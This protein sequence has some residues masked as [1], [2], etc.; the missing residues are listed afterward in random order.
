DIVPEF[1][2]LTSLPE[3]NQVNHEA[4][5]AMGK[6][7]NDEL[8]M[9]ASVEPIDFNV[10]ID[11]LYGDAE[12]YDMYTVGWSGRVDRIDPDMF[13]YAIFH[14][15]AAIP[16]WNNTTRFK[17][18]AYDEI[19]DAQRNE[20][21]ESKRQ[22]LVYEA[23]EMLADEAPLITLYARDLVHAYNNELFDIITVMSG[24]GFFNK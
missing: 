18:D 21:D 13:I 15:T 6:V 14:S 12:D 7:W 2:L 5:N 3:T 10:L 8:G 16:G 1:S 23:Q 4:A 22:E 19:A 24:E 11:R 17:S 9:D 20:M